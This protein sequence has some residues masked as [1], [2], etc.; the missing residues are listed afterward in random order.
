[1]KTLLSTLNEGISGNLRSIKEALEKSNRALKNGSKYK[2][3]DTVIRQIFKKLK[4]DGIFDDKGNVT[5]TQ[6]HVDNHKNVLEL[7][8]F[9]EMMEGDPIKNIE[10]IIGQKLNLK[11]DWFVNFIPN[12]DYFDISISGIIVSD[13]KY[14]DFEKAVEKRLYGSLVDLGSKGTDNFVEIKLLY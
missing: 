9:L 14:Y 4:M 1:M 3:F 13:D 12:Q 8:K 2:Q 7:A 6:S 11:K 10:K 5:L